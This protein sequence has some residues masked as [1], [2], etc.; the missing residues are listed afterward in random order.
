MRTPELYEAVE[1]PA[2]QRMDEA[3]TAHADSRCLGACRAYFRV[4][5]AGSKSADA[6]REAQR[7]SSI[8]ASRATRQPRFLTATRRDGASWAHFGV[9][10]P[11]RTIGTPSGSRLELRPTRLRRIRES[12][13]DRLLAH[14]GRSQLRVDAVT[15]DRVGT[16]AALN[17]AFAGE[18][19]ERGDDDV[20]SGH[21][22]ELAQLR[23][24]LASPEAV[25]AEHRHLRFDVRGDQL[26]I[27]AHVVGCGDDRR[28]TGKAAVE[29]ARSGLALGMQPVVALDF[30]RLARKLG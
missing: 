21:F 27:C 29:M 7:I 5:V 23:S 8:F 15:C 14:P 12:K 25:G 13:P 30:A 6:R 3:R 20:A 18:R 19:I 11:H 1:A 10:R 9:A 17:R 16:D 26:R 2:I 24:R 28:V 4:S 22:E